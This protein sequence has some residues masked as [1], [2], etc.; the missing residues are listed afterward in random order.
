MRFFLLALLIFSAQPAYAE[1]DCWNADRT[2]YDCNQ[3]GG[4]VTKK[5]VPTAGDVIQSNPA[6]LPVH[7]T[8]FGLEG[9]VSNRSDPTGKMKFAGS[10]IKGFE[11]IGFGIGSWSE[12]TFSA[13][14]FRNHFLGTTYAQDYRNYETDSSKAQ[15]FRLG[16]S[17][18]LPLGLPNG[19]ELSVGGSL[20]QGRVKKSLAR[21]TGLVL[22][23]FMFGFGYAQSY[24]KLS[25]A[26]PHPRVDTFSTGIFL[27]S[28]FFGYYTNTVKSVAGKTYSN[29]Y[30]ANW[31]TSKWTFYG[32]IKSYKDYRDIPQTWFTGKV[33]RT[34]GKRLG[35]GYIYGFYQRSH[36]ISMQLYL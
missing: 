20:G 24:E 31:E 11:G 16:T 18:R 23:M 33:Q 9:I 25:I 19:M 6:A 4:G 12:D 13:P 30:A 32:A 15:S 28:L 21:Q 7:H 10:T 17:V 2:T 22:R 34:F 1:R 35:F 5:S 26:L 27:Y 3:G 29:T 8:G 14:D 36:S